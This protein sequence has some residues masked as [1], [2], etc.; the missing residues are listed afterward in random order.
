MN[1]VDGRILIVSLFPFL[2][3][4]LVVAQTH[5]LDA[6]KTQEYWTV[7][8]VLQ[9]SGRI[10]KDTHYATVLRHEPPKDKALAWETGDPVP[11]AAALIL[12]QNRQ[13]IAPRLTS[14][15]Q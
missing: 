12:F 3:P 1:I 4:A 6:L 8:E 15:P 5:P 14:P 10:D 2:A 7:Y 11:R 9:K 13:V